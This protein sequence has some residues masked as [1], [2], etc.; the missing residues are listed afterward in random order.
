MQA[1]ILKILEGQVAKFL[2][3]LF[4]KYLGKTYLL[5]LSLSNLFEN[6]GILV[7]QETQKRSISIVNNFKNYKNSRLEKSVEYNFLIQIILYYK[8]INFIIYTIYF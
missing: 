2:P 6:F 3:I 1:K 4:L 5:I 7:C 8:I